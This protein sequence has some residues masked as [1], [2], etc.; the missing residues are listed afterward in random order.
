MFVGCA[1]KLIDPM[2]RSNTVMTEPHLHPLFHT[3]SIIDDKWVLIERIGKGGMGEVFRAH[4]LN[5][6][7]DV[8]IKIISEDLMQSFEDNPEERTAAGE[9]IKT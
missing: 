3:G 2:A 7:R 6:D 4:Q 9:T 5:L 8:A 1:A